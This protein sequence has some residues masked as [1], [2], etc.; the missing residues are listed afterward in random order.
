MIVVNLEVFVERQIV[1][2]VLRPEKI[3]DK[4]KAMFRKAMEDYSL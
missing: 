3:S 1:M 4:H 2:K